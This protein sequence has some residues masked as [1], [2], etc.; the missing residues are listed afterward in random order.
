ML[1]ATCTLL[2]NFGLE[3]LT[4]NHIAK[5][6][7]VTVGSIYQ[8]FPNKQAILLELT[9][10]LFEDVNKKTLQYI[11]NHKSMT[12]P[13]EFMRGL[14]IYFAIEYRSP[15]HGAEVELNKAL[16][17]FPELT[18]LE[19]KN[20]TKQATFLKAIFRHYGSEWQEQKLQK[21]CFVAYENLL[22]NAYQVATAKNKD[23]AFR[24]EWALQICDTLTKIPLDIFAQTKTDTSA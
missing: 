15:V 23:K 6:S 14:L 20:K 2:A 17:A 3:K 10:C 9:T 5:E 8:F 21:Y 24:L 19:V 7:Q 12:D 18:A 4:T 11:D 13:Q 1:D 16:I 22:F